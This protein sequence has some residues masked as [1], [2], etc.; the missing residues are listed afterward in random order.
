M[1]RSVPQIAVL[2]SLIS[3]SF[4]PISGTGTCSIQMPL[5]GSRLT[6]AFIICGMAFRSQRNAHYRR[7][8]RGRVRG[9]SRAIQGRPRRNIDPLLSLR[10]D[11][12]DRCDGLAERAP[13]LLE[14]VI[15]LQADP[16]AP[17]GAEC[18]GEANGRICAQAALAEHDFVDP[19]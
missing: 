13:R 10:S 11:A 3:T 19:A 14:V 7:A 2:I 5:A 15:G 8:M 16:E 4:G 9:T 18:G 1:C 6:S 17:A 12:F